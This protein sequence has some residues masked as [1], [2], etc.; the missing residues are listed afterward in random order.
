VSNSKFMNYIEAH[1]GHNQKIT[2]KLEKYLG[3]HFPI[4]SGLLDIQNFIKQRI[5]RSSSAPGRVI[6]GKDDWLF[7]GEDFGDPLKESLGIRRPT[8][9]QI[10]SIANFLKETNSLLNKNGIKFIFAV[11]PNKHEVYSEFLDVPRAG[12]SMLD[13]LKLR[14]G[15]DE[16]LDRKLQYD[17]PVLKLLN[18]SDYKVDIKKKNFDELTKVLR[19]NKEIERLVLVEKLP[20]NVTSRPRK[21]EVPKN[22]YGDAM[23]YERRYGSDVNNLDCI[24]IGDSFSGR[25]FRFL[26]TGFGNFTFINHV[27]LDLQMVIKEKPDVFI[28]EIVERNIDQIPVAG[29]FLAEI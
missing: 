8:D 20:V 6:M 13:R 10:D 18:L 28:Y 11:A 23:I 15:L 16:F 12:P 9:H 22:Y 17:F 24:F 3:D 25:M 1:K 14:D 2:N 26:R 29:R 19:S 7:L 27:M 21:L 5:F 4:R